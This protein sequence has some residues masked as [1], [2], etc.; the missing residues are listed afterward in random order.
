M[1]DCHNC[2]ADSAPNDYI[3]VGANKDKICAYCARRI[4]LAI[5][6]RR[7]TGYDSMCLNAN[8]RADTVMKIGRA[9]V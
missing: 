7:D 6:R 1:N 8:T 5:G 2:C 3:L 4:G 9:H